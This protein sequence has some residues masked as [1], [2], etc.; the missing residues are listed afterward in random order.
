MTPEEQRRLARLWFEVERLLFSPAKSGDRR[1]WCDRF[2][3]SLAGYWQSEEF[4]PPPSAFPTAEFSL[5]LPGFSIC[6]D[7][8]GWSAQGGRA[9]VRAKFEQTVLAS[10]D[11][12]HNWCDRAAL[13]EPPGGPVLAHYRNLRTL[14]DDLLQD[15]TWVLDNLIVHPC[16][17][18]H[19]EG[20]ILQRLKERPRGLDDQFKGVLHE[21]RLG[22]GLTNPFAALFQLRLQFALGRDKAETIQRKKDECKRVAGLACI[23]IRDKKLTVPA[24]D[25]FP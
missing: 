16:A 22:L 11:M 17:H 3:G 24:G 25:L 1:T 19:A 4:L 21:V 9:S 23:A 2:L 5:P 14:A 15:A 10:H 13:S 18:L 20:D 8:S 6:Y 12:D 7:L